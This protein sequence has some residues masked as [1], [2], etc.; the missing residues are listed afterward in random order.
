M[1]LSKDTKVTLTLEQL[2]R[3][4]QKAAEKAVKKVITEM[5]EEGVFDGSSGERKQDKKQR[6]LIETFRLMQ[7]QMAMIAEQM[8]GGQVA[9]RRSP[10]RGVDRND[11][12][13]IVYDIGPNES[14]FDKVK[15]SGS[16]ESVMAASAK[17]QYTGAPEPINEAY[18]A[19]G[20]GNDDDMRVRPEVVTRVANKVRDLRERAVTDE[21]QAYLDVM[22][23][24]D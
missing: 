14:K 18:D 5:A 2:A 16:R 20:N 12:T 8:G 24:D 22:L 19:Y 17:R 7:E 21:E 3:V 11:P 23:S 9:P 10:Q 6:E 15:S 13:Q 4:A 1:G